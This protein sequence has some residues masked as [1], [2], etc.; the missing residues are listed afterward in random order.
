MFEVI[1]ISAHEILDSRGGPTISVAVELFSKH[2]GTASVPSGMSLGT[3]E[4]HELR[5]GD[6]ER[7][8][9]DGT[10]LAVGNVK[11]EIARLVRGRKFADLAELDEALA[12][13]DGTRNKSRLGANAICGVSMAIARAAAS[14]EGQ[15]LWCSLMPEGVTPR[16]PLPYF[17]IVNGAKHAPNELEFQEFMVVPVG[18]PAFVDA[19]RA[20]ADIHRAFR[21]A[22]VHEGLGR[23]L[24]DDRGFAPGID[25]PE[26]VLSLLVAAIDDAG[27]RA[28][29]SEIAIALDP[30]ASHFYRDEGYHVAGAT[31]SA[32]AMIDW[33]ADLVENF[34]ISSIEDGLAEDDW[35]GW[36]HLTSRLGDRLQIVGDDIFVT[37]AE[38]IVSGV[39]H[40]VANAALIKP[41]QIGTVTETFEAMRVC[42]GA[43][44]SQIVSHRAGDTDDTFIAD[45]AVGSGCGRI[46]AGAPIRGEHVA[47]YN[48]L[49]EIETDACLPYGAAD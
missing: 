19:V 18:A 26:A 42:R 34:P 38:L 6:D 45:L 32:T 33:Y 12:H 15:P 48:R 17:N 23:A 14:Q 2:T 8:A 11:G 24:G 25:D 49:I 35:Q 21:R 5:D 28:D 29:R 36:Q 30:A 40:R 20:G 43:D 46:K 31:L 9:G 13:L 37:N 22:L 7:Y 47:K 10:R 41:N 44:W 27:Y 1:W 3:R 39:D 16:V 4:A